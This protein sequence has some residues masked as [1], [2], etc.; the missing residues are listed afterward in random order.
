MAAGL[1]RP[2]V[3]IVK[4]F[5]MSKKSKPNGAKADP[6]YIRVPATGSFGMLVEE[7]KS[8][9]GRLFFRHDDVPADTIPA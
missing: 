6:K 7:V 1:P 2:L 8:Q 9:N 3:S 5:V 4:T